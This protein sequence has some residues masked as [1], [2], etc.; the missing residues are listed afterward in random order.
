[1]FLEDCREKKKKQSKLRET[2][3]GKIKQQ[4]QVRAVPEATGDK[5]SCPGC[6]WMERHCPSSVESK[7]EDIAVRC[8]ES[9]GLKAAFA[10]PAGRFSKATSGDGG[11]KVT[12]L[13]FYL[14]LVTMKAKLKKRL[15]CTPDKFTLMQLILRVKQ[16]QKFA[17]FSSY[18]EKEKIYSPGSVRSVNGF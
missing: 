18:R 6:E 17:S 3:S 9:A 14:N 5:L 8:W 11:T 1:M 7:G 13:E 2:S 15:K 4:P 10:A 16:P 12:S